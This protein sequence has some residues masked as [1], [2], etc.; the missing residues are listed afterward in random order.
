[1]P[2]YINVPV[3]SELVP[4]VYALIARHQAVG[5][6]TISTSPKSLGT[7]GGTTDESREWT[8]GEFDILAASEAPS[9]KTFCE[10]LDLLAH[11]SPAVMTVSEIGDHLGVEGLTLQK[12]FGAV[13]RWM[14]GRIGGGVRWPIHITPN[15]E[16]CMSE[17]NAELWTQVR[18]EQ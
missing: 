13:T 17:R 2:E 18:R 9:V 6:A 15:R 12:K 11:R 4:D 1:M 7:Q 14:Q 3:P 10:V 8:R 5:G 16:W